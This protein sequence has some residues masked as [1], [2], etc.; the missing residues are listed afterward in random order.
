LEDESRRQLIPHTSQ[1]GE[2]AQRPGSVGL[3]FDHA[4]PFD[5]SVRNAPWAEYAILDTLNG[6][7]T[8]ELHHVPFD[9]QTFIQVTLASGMPHAKWSAGEWGFNEYSQ[10]K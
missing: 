2:D 5:N 9:V 10:I 8:V 1:A 6:A 3:A 7:I 4:W